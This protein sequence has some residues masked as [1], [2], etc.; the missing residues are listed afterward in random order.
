MQK[1]LLIIAFI[2]LFAC[3]DRKKETIDRAIRSKES[4]KGIQ[5]SSYTILRELAD[6]T[7]LTVYYK[8]QLNPGSHVTEVNDSIIFYETGDGILQ[9][10]P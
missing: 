7:K 2:L 10:L 5:L 8:A 9:P 4:S 3:Y 1:P 6:S